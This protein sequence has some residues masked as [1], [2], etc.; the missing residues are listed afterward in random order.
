M[1]I[2]QPFISKNVV[3]FNTYRNLTE[4]V[5]NPLSPGREAWQEG[6]PAIK[7]RLE[8]EEDLGAP[9]F[10]RPR[11]LELMIG[12]RFDVGAGAVTHLI[13]WLAVSDSLHL[14]THFTTPFTTRFLDAKALH[15]DAA[16]DE[17]LRIRDRQNFRQPSVQQRLEIGALGENFTLL[18][19]LD[20]AELAGKTQQRQGS[21]RKK[22]FKRRAVSDESHIRRMLDDFEW[23]AHDGILPLVWRFATTVRLR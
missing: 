1:R 17:L 8:I 11:H 10:R 19:L 12:D 22:L 21:I 18:A 7:N 13:E 4:R 16:K 5:P 20:S 23:S 15:F 6:G 3:R 14:A 2:T 9:A